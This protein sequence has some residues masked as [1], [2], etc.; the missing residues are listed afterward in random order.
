[1][2]SNA[3]DCDSNYNSDTRDAYIDELFDAEYN[4][5]CP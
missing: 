2:Y 4:L 3:Q 5:A 1:M